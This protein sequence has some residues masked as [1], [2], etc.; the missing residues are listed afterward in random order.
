[1]TRWHFLTPLFVIGLAAISADAG[2]ADGGAFVF[3][4]TGIRVPGQAVLL[5]IDD[6]SLPL[7]RDMCLYL[8]K[9][10]VRPEPVLT[11]TRDNPNAPDFLA[12]HF[13]GTV[14]FENGKFRMWY[15]ACHLG[16]NPDWP[17]ALSAQADR[18]KGNI[19]PGPLCYAESDDGLN[20]TKPNL[21]QLLFKG[22]RDNNAF[23]LPSALTGDA[24]V[25]RDDA[26]PNPAR[27]YKLAF[28]TQ[29]DPY[30]YPTMRLAVSPDGI[31]WAATEKPP[32]EAFLEH[33]SF[34]Q[35]N[36]YFFANAQT[37]LPGESGRERGRQG[38]AWI[39][40]DF[41]HWIPECAE[42]F[43]LPYAEGPRRDEVHLGV[44]AAGF[45]NVLVG[46]YCIWHNDAEFANISGDLGLV[47][48]NNGLAFREPVKGHTWLST[49]ESPVT[50][51]PGKSYNTVLCQANGILNVGDETRIYHGRWR[52]AGSLKP[53][54]EE[55]DYYAEVALATLPRD[56][57]GAL[58]LVPGKS[59]G[60]FWTAP[61]NLPEGGCELLLNAD[62]VAGMRVDIS[63]ERFNLLPEYSGDRAGTV[64]GTDGLDCPVAWAD[65]T[66][67]A[68]GGKAVR[69]RV[70]VQ[71]EGAAEPRVY[72]LYL[73]ETGN[74]APAVSTLE[75][76]TTPAGTSFAILPAAKRPA[77][78]LLVCATTAEETLT[79]EMYGSSPRILHGKGWNVV[80][81]DL[82][83]HGADHRE[84]ERQQLEGWRDRVEN[85]ENIV[86][87]WQRR[88]NDV[89]DHLIASGVA[90][91]ERIYAEGTSRGGYMACQAA[92]ANP[93]IRAVAAYAPVTELPALREFEGL[94]ADPLTRQLDLQNSAAAL[95]NRPLWIIIGNAD[96]RVGTD[97]AVAFS[98]RLAAA[99]QEQGLTPD[100]TLQVVP[101]PG[102]GSRIEWH[103]AAI[104]W[105]LEK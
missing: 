61:V 5:A 24:C 43:A 80:A 102:H 82:P 79:H 10:A 12:T 72:A 38:A 85:G 54:I 31:H 36:G 39:S 27:R 25:V 104:A 103:D 1:M 30:D 59:E 11:P 33:A 89:L 41:D 55:Q 68:L 14:L 76:S 40:A 60:S 62:A 84:G 83:C 101:V 66:L 26:D 90:D 22:S 17:P 37:F 78:T 16:R 23:D 93:K 53:G 20:W 74:I 69:F 100:V 47:V 48:S 44:G 15:Y 67:G 9:P 29:Y 75:V 50:P 86:T 96:D 71:R 46:L 21:G 91:P 65:S 8:S 70:R 77:P 52:N 32:I 18:W 35:H 94:D 105:M 97:R 2:L 42:S 88:V 57:W 28:W 6:A 87:D 49:A 56:R 92:A 64:N 99:A 73:R 13:Y 4:S 7:K 58:G 63:D 45:G 19:I 51:A 98:R 95:C 3:P 34:Y 81:L